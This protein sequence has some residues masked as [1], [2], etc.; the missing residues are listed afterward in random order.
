MTQPREWKRGRQRYRVLRL[1]ARS[2]LVACAAA[3]IL[4][5]QTPKPPRGPVLVLTVDGDVNPVL[6]QYLERGLREGARRNAEM[7]LIRLDTPGGELEC[8]REIA[9][10]FLA[11]EVPIGVYVWPPG[12]RAGSAG[13]FI[14]MAAHVAAMAPSTNIGAAHPIMAPTGTGEEPPQGDQLKTL[15]DKAT[16]DAVALIRNLAQQH[17]RNADWAE[18]AVRQSVSATADEAA[19]LNAV[20]FVA[21]DLEDFLRW[22]DGR[23]VELPSGKR[24]LQTASAPVDFIPMNWREALLFRLVN[25]NVAYILMILGM[26]GLIVE[27]KTPGFGGAGV[28]G[29][30]CLILGLYAL[31]I[32]QANLA[33]VALILVGIGFF[34]GELVAP[35]HGLLTLGGA[36]AFAVGS[37]ILFGSSDTGVSRPLIAGVVAST[38]GFFVF[39][40][41]AIVKGQRRKVVTG[42]QGMIGRIGE[43]RRPLNPTGTVFADGTL[44]TA[45]A[46]EEAIEVG[47]KVEIVQVEGL[48]LKVRRASDVQADQSPPATS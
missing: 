12:G 40:L 14:T 45:E 2:G 13:T 44:W 28:L 9:R 26:Y 27:L 37:L 39:V 16:N 31:S 23:T 8:T 7:V 20:D 4:A 24:V 34:Y 42:I 48:R 18:K 47:E 10:D 43:V 19:R 6:V 35:T 41:G 21:K 3:A 32:L 5:A 22:A 33:G 30:I 15:T 17:G 46:G 36:I 38:V 11:S 25:P 1:A 29:A